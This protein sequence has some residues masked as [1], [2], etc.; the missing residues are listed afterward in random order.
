MGFQK[1]RLDTVTTRTKSAALM[2]PFNLALLAA[3]T[4]ASNVLTLVLSIIFH[5]LYF[6]ISRFW[7]WF[8]SLLFLYL[9]SHFYFYF[10]CP[11][12]QPSS[13][14]T[15]ALVGIILEFTFLAE[16]Q[17]PKGRRFSC[18]LMVSCLCSSLKIQLCQSRSRF[19]RS[20]CSTHH[21][22]LLTAGC[23]NTLV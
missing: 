20:V 15:W 3:L 23:G 11:P 6:L 7:F 13:C 4:R 12:P 18:V 1:V 10:P 16:N 21:S 8:S 22:T 5:P 9:L 19:Y 2:N 14:T 17:L